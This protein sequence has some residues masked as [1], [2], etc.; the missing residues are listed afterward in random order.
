M[1]S[2]TSE[3]SALQVE[4]LAFVGFV[5]RI[6]L[7]TKSN[8][9]HPLRVSE[10][11]RNVPQAILLYLTQHTGYL[12]HWV[13]I[14]SGLGMFAYPGVISRST[15][16]SLSREISCFLKMFAILSASEFPLSINLGIVDPDVSN[17]RPRLVSTFIRPTFLLYCQ[18]R[19]VGL[20][21][22]I[23]ANSGN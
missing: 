22:A 2:I 16:K 23:A 8:Y 18:R 7:L 21:K 12:R 11:G 4:H 15:A 1:F 19:N 9:S 17:C 6:T 13:R 20:I 10:K 14:Y 3:N 5:A